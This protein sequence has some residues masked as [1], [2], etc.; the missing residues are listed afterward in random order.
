MSWTPKKVSKLKELWGKGNTAAQIASI[1]GEVTRNAVIGKAYRL[2]LTE[3]SFSKNINFKH[4]SRN[5]KMLHNLKEK[6]AEVN[7]SHC[8]WTKILNQKIQSP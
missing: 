2:K 3:K 4:I 6:H 1:I 7:L 8:C 5:L